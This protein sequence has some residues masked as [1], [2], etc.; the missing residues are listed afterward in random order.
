ML[1]VPFVM[2]LVFT[3]DDASYNQVIPKEK[4]FKVSVNENCLMGSQSCKQK[5]Y[6]NV[7]LPNTFLKFATFP[8]FLIKTKCAVHRNCFC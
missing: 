2:S 3:I 7:D 8:N 1:L 6:E 5:A 4:S